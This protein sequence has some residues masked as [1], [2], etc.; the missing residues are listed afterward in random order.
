MHPLQSKR[1]VVGITGGIAAYKSIELIRLLRKNQA[2]VRVV[3]TPAAAEFVTPLT[4][5]A[6]SGNAVAQS[7]LDPQAELAMGH[8]ELAKWAEAIVIAP[9]SADFLARLTVGMANDLLSTLCLATKAPFYSLR[10]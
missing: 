2:D 9:A 6:I 3:L 8:I 10:R 7:L 5:Q 4:L 1:I